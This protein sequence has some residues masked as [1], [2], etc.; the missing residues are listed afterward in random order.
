T[1]LVDRVLFDIDDA[2]GRVRPGRLAH[3][4]VAGCAS[5]ERPRIRVE[6][7][8]SAGNPDVAV[9]L[10]GARANRPC[11]D[12]LSTERLSHQGASMST[13]ASGSDSTYK[14]PS[15][16]YFSPQNSH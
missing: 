6:R 15:A 9:R 14:F 1:D 7:E 5:G 13:G 2:V 10:F 4:V 11:V 3:E 16:S 12:G 8:F